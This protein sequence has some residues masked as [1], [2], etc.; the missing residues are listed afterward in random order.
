[1]VPLKT[2][3]LTAFALLGAPFAFALDAVEQ[4][5]KPV[6]AVAAVTGSV[7]VQRGE[8]IQRAFVNR[9][10]YVRDSISTGDNGSIKIIFTD[11]SIVDLGPGSQFEV[12]SFEHTQAQ[13]RTGV[14]TLIYGRLRALI[15]KSF[16]SS[17]KLDVRSGEVVMGVRGTEFVVNT[18]RTSPGQAARARLTVLEGSVSLALPGLPLQLIPAGQQVFAAGDAKAPPTPVTLT[19]TQLGEISGASAIQDRTFDDA[20]EVNEKDSGEPQGSAA[21][22]DAR[23]FAMAGDVI[24]GAADAVADDK[25]AHRRI[26]DRVL[27]DKREPIHDVRAVLLPGS[28]KTVKVTLSH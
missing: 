3:A 15:S 6:A 1:M 16:S 12:E 21:P 2:A 28:F 10:L 25:M 19:T 23:P 26:M 27:K 22:P 24:A 7:S 9:S 17:S 13:T 14:L 18:Q 20:V 5:G 8:E 4:A 11:D